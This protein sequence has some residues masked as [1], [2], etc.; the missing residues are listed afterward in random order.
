MDYKKESETI[1]ILKK[2]LA[3]AV[4][5]SLPLGASLNIKKLR[6]EAYILEAIAEIEESPKDSS[7]LQMEKGEEK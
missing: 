2:A 6:L 5:K 1:K 7:T 3:L 4:I